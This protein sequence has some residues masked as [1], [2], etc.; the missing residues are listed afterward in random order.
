MVSWTA[1]SLLLSAL[2]A[3]SLP[4]NEAQHTFADD[5]HPGPINPLKREL[6][7]SIDGAPCPPQDTC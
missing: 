1:L 5:Y 2:G 6:H 3:S 7:Y 4:A